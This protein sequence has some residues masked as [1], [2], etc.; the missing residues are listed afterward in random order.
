MAAKGELVGIAGLSL[1]TTLVTLA[2]IL[3][4]GIYLGILIF[5]ESSLLVLT[6]L[7]HKKEFLVEERSQLQVENQKL[8]KEYFE[9]KQLEFVEE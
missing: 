3:I 9:L 4:F 8:Q 2:G 7:K 6:H 5:G 1:R